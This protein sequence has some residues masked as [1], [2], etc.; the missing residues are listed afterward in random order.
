MHKRILVV[1]SF[2]TLLIVATLSK[3]ENSKSSQPIDIYTTEQN[4]VKET[5][6]YT[7]NDFVAARPNTFELSAS[8]DSIDDIELQD[9]GY[10]T[11]EY[12]LTGKS[13]SEFIAQN[14]IVNI[15]QQVAYSSYDGIPNSQGEYAT[16]I[17]SDSR[18]TTI[19]SIWPVRPVT[20]FELASEAEGCVY[21]SYLVEISARFTV[22]SDQKDTDKTDMTVEYVCEFNANGFVLNA[23]SII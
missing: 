9:E 19:K 21:M 17:E 18:I 6:V 23:I 22:V 5:L 3:F 4:A 2:T 14:N 20:N 8:S 15:E 7:Q 13:L 16:I 12:V 11:P 1:A 10:S